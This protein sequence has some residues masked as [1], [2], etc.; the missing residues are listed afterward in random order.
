MTEQPD[1]DI[2]TDLPEF[3]GDQASA[4]AEEVEPDEPDTGELLDEGEEP[5]GAADVPYP[6]DDFDEPQDDEATEG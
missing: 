2:L 6:Y 4:D 3:A 1:V 5:A